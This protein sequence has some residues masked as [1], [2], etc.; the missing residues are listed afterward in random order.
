MFTAAHLQALRGCQTQRQGG[1]VSWSAAVAG[2][3]RP[4]RFPCL[5]VCFFVLRTFASLRQSVPVSIPG[6]PSRRAQEIKK[7][8]PGEGRAAFPWRQ[9]RKN[10]KIG[11]MD[12]IAALPMAKRRR[13]RIKPKPFRQATLLGKAALPLFQ[14][15][16]PSWRAFCLSKS[17]AMRPEKS[18][19][20]AT[21]FC[22]KNIYPAQFAAGNF[23]KRK[24]IAT[25]PG[26]A[27]RSN[28]NSRRGGKRTFPSAQAVERFGRPS[29]PRR[30]RLPLAPIFLRQTP[31]APRR[32]AACPRAR[33]R[34]RALR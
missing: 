12:P 7:T 23:Q 19:P 1:E 2:R 17:I 20:P 18:N 15:P 26:S 24:Q 4:C 9:A 6:L 14:H 5:Q 29:R 32:P 25:G 31:C 27:K 34:G 33:P 30:R 11:D 16:V 8:F 3:L 21:S 10:N 28:Q 22:R 13:F